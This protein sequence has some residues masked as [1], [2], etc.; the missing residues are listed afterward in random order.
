MNYAH[1]N[2]PNVM[3]FGT[4]MSAAM[5]KIVYAAACTE[6][7]NRQKSLAVGCLR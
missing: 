5:P 2:K 7:A 1:T 4:A 3:L 6:L